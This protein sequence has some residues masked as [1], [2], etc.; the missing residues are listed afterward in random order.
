MASLSK[1]YTPHESESKWYQFWLDNQLFKADAH[2]NKPSYCIVI[3]PPNVTGQLH[4]GHALVNTLQDMQIRWHR[5]R[6]F[7]ALWVPG[8]DHAG[9][10]TQTVV[11]K[12]LMKT[13]GKKRTDLTREEFLKRTF[14]WKEIYEERITGQL[15]KLGCSCDWSRQRFTMDEESN[16][17]V[18]KAFKKLYD[19]GLIYRG[20]YLVNWDPITQTALSDDELEYE[21]RST[22]LWHFN[23]PL[24]D[25]SGFIEIATTRPETMLGDT[26]IAV[27]PKDGRYASFIGKEI[28]H[29]I[30]DRTFPVIADHHVDPEFGT[31]AVKITP[32]HDPNDYEMAFRHDLPMINI[33]NPDA[34]LNENTG[35]F[36][37]LSINESREKVLSKLKELNLF[38]KQTPHL[39]RVA[40]SYRSKA[41]IEPYLSKQWFVKM[42][43]FKD[44]MRAIVEDKRV[45]IL[46]ESWQKTYFHW[47]DNLR[48]WCI[49]RQLWWGHQIPIWY[50]K[51]NPDTIICYADEG[52]PSEVSDNPNSWVQDTDVLDTWFSSALWP[53][54]VLGGPEAT[55]DMKKFYP[56]STLITGHDILFFWVARMI[57]FGEH[58]TGT[59][60][61]PEV[62]LHGLIFG[63]SYWRTDSDG[64][65][66]YVSEEERQSYDLGEKAPKDVSSKWEKMSK[67]KGNVIDPNKMIEQYGTDAVRMTLAS[68]AS[69]NR[70]I[71]LDMRLFEEYR[72]FANKVWN[73]ARFILSNLDGDLERGQEPLTVEEIEKGIDPT[74]MM[75]ED[76]WIL[77]QLNETTNFVNSSLKEYGFDKATKSAYEFFWKEVCAYYLEIAKPYLYLRVETPDADKIRTNKQKILWILLSASIRLLHPVAPFITEEIFQILLPNYQDATPASNCDSLSVEAMHAYKTNSCCKAAYPENLK[78]DLV[79]QKLAH[80]FDTLQELLTLIRQLRSEM[81]LKSTATELI[82]KGPV[83]NSA[84]QLIEKQKHVIEALIPISSLQIQNSN[85]SS[86]LTSSLSAT[87]TMGPIEVT[88][89]LP[90]TLVAKEVERLNKDIF[91][92]EKQIGSL[93]KQLT[94][95]QFIERAPEELV[96]SKREQLSNLKSSLEISRNKI[97]SL[98]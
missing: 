13:E 53:F 39:N 28:Q 93:E 54:S 5:M 87:G 79:D 16:K 61:F 83:D 88:V 30:Q 85:E 46:P 14:E 94:N 55:D 6:G 84:F 57:C 81:D 63:K 47:I 36:E 1:Q 78:I 65:V 71:D 95:Q 17:L 9:I 20:D 77:N 48:D 72:N 15:K 68:I 62:F 29:P 38:V 3:P 66:H 74:L 25:G 60:P 64:V 21:E 41:T 50:N 73:G 51:D 59:A 37:G 11:E 86:I 49:S 42:S 96:N 45:N 23:Y 35:A 32:A 92:Y 19:E 80:Q 76:H 7:E 33:L 24:A 58:F 18:R 40:I 10:A 56:N 67:S 26:A 69:S 34:T 31:G 89:P 91:K 4:M 98:S 43:A 12:Q 70:Q 2:S 75:I 44:K 22:F 52:V 90:H 8:T 97:A 27:N 82:I